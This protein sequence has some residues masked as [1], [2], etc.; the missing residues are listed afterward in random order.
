[1]TP[2]PQD[3]YKDAVIYELHVRSFADSNADGMGDFRGLTSRL[4]YLADLGVNAIWILPFYPS[5]WRD[6]GY[7]ISDY[8]SIHEAYGT[9]RDFRAFLKGAHDRDLRVITELVINHTSNRHPWFEKSRTAPPGSSW[10]DYYVWSDTPEKYTEA[11]IIFQDFETSNWSWDPVAGAYYWHRFYS[12]QPDLNFDNPAVQDEVFRVLD[13]WFSLGVDGLRLDAIPYLFER[14]GTNCENLPITH[15]FLK[16]MRSH[17]D[18][19]YPGRMLLAEANQWPEDAVT[20]FG[21]GTG[22]ECHMA[23]HFP[24]M[25]RLFMAMKMEDS[26]PVIN[27]LEQTPAI[28]ETSQ[29]GIFLRNHDELTLE[30]VTDEERDYMYRAYGR[31]PRHRIN[32]GI[33]RRL[34]PLLDNNRRGIELLNSLLFSLPGTPVIYYGDEIGMGDNVYLGDRDGVRTPMQWSPD[35]NAGF[36][37]SNPQQL[38]LPVIIDPE[39]HFEAVNVETQQANGSSL[40]WWMKRLIAARRRF[41]AFS[42]GTLDVV[43]T[44]NHRIFAFLRQYEEQVILVVVNFSRHTQVVEL[45]LGD[46]M[47]YQ[48]EEVFSHSPFPPVRDEHYTLTIGSNDFYWLQLHAPAQEGGGYT[49]AHPGGLAVSPRQWNTLDPVLRRSL[50]RNVL[51]PYMYAS[52]WFRS[53]ARVSRMVEIENA[54]PFGG[55]PPQTWLLV[56]RITFTDDGTERYVVPL[57]LARGTEAQDLLTDDPGSIV[58]PITL[59]DEEG[60][61]YDGVASPAFRT[62][63]MD[64]LRR[65]GRSTPPLEGFRGTALRRTIKSLEDH[66]EGDIPS[67]VFRVEQSNSAILY[68][69]RLFLKL[70]R[71]LENGIQPDIELLRF[72]SEERGFLHVPRFQGS[73]EYRDGHGDSAAL[74]LLIDAVENHGDAWQ[75]T[76]DTIDRFFENIL[77]SSEGVV[78]V[79]RVPASPLDVDPGKIPE[80]FWDLCDGFFLEMVELL[81]RRTAEMHRALGTADSGSPFAPEPFSRLYQRSLYQSMR[82]LTRRILDTARRKGGMDELLADE[83]EI[84]AVFSRV[85]GDLIPARKIR[86]HGDYHLGQVLYTGRDFVII[87]MEGEPGR[88]LSERRLKFSPLRDVAGMLRSFHYA[89]YGRFLEASENRPEDAARIEPWLRPWYVWVSGIFITAYLQHMKGSSFL[90]EDPAVL[91]RLLQAYLLEKAMYEVGYEMNNRPEWVRIPLEGIRLILEDHRTAD[92]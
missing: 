39:Y 67:A 64:V 70:Y 50:E 1:M 38:Y 52:R 83:K 63:L 45:R 55:R 9:M 79:P 7:D 84:M 56:M 48:L 25:P 86:I 82:S 40:L 27:I 2:Q 68:G 58:C 89:V 53:K 36:S 34:A 15:Q 47:G 61:L 10:R 43:A 51:L 28:P 78:R 14:E 35:K 88:T 87:D 18:R 57:A 19:T 13:F 37:G 4:D 11:R 49:G 20:Y 21:E 24:L 76:G 65:R 8:R 60:V 90:P 31:D 72:L 26:F 6:D 74:A 41:P 29:W 71:K 42:R 85:T 66:H 33:R 59:G 17:V 77:M 73:I 91:S 3:W 5:P 32:L 62:A 80:V 69:D 12:H 92:P 22:D 16:K 75:Y 54:L 46:F 23:F 81:G 30:M 44:N